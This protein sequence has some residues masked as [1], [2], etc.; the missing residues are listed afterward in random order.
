MTTTYTNGH[1]ATVLDL[2]QRRKRQ[3]QRNVQKRQKSVTFGNVQQYQQS[4]PLYSS[5]AAGSKS[6]DGKAVHVPMKQNKFHHRRLSPVTNGVVHSGDPMQSNNP[7]HRHVTGQYFVR[8]ATENP[9]Y[10]SKS[11]ARS[12]GHA[13]PQRVPHGVPAMTA[14]VYG[15]PPYSVY[16][17][18]PAQSAYAYA[19]A[20]PPHPVYP[21]NGV[22]GVQYPMYPQPVVPPMNGMHTMNGVN[23]VNGMLSMNPP[24]M[25]QS[26]PS[27]MYPQAVPVPS[28]SAYAMP[29]TALSM[30]AA[31]ASASSGDSVHQPAVCKP[32]GAGKHQFGLCPM[33]GSAKG[34]RWGG[35]CFYKHSDPN[36][37]K[38]CPDFRKP[39]GCRFG[40]R[41]FNRHQTFVF[42]KRGDPV[43]K[44]YPQKVVEYKEAEHSM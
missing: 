44:F 28:A 34:C 41:C 21:P 25:R 31:S 19:R 4:I 13:L 37:V 15:Y 8:Y 27:Q 42:V 22:S 11:R 1:V 26:M 23:T 39:E 38:F 3:G 9:N 10:P 6:S 16:P 36:S 17:Q 32:V 30:A 7:K 43:P 35:D 12:G 24:M 14:P 33:F 29:S 2:E 20:G 5:V 40:D 18:H